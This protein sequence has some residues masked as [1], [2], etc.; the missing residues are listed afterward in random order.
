MNLPTQRPLG[1]AMTLALLL[2]TTP[3]AAPAFAEEAAANQQPS[4]A[5][6]DIVVTGAVQRGLQAEEEAAIGVLDIEETG[7]ISLR[8]QTN[9]A[10]IAKRLPGLSTSV[11]QGRNGS[12]TGEAQYVAIRG[13]QT[14]FNAYTL[15]GIRLPQTAGTGT[16]AISLN[17]F[18][19]FAISGIVA[20]K[21][22]GAAQDAD[23]IAGIIDLRTPTAF[24]FGAGFVR[25]RA[26]TQVAQR[27]LQ[28]D[29]D[30]WG[31]ALGVDGAQRFGDANQFG[32]YA[33]AYYEQRNS[34]AESVAT[35]DPW[36]STFDNGLTAR[37][38]EDALSGRGI[39][40]N[41]FNAE[42]ERYGA[43][44]S[45][46][47]RTDRLELF[48]RVNWA[49]YDIANT[50]NQT[51][52][53][54][55]TVSGQTNP[56][57][58]DA[59]GVFQPIGANP[60]H[61]FRV[62]DVEQELFSTH[63][64]G[65]WK[66]ERLSI[67][68]SGAY[69]D[70]RLDQPRSHTAAFRGI[71]YIG[72]PGQTGL[73]R[74]GVGIDISDPKWPTPI[75]SPGAADYVASLERPQ[76]YYVQ[77]NQ[78]YLSEDKWTIKGDVSWS[79]DGAL[80]LVQVGGLWEDA[81]RDGLS[82]DDGSLRYR[83]RTDLY[84]GT[85][86]GGPLA[87]F[88]GEVLDDFL[89]HRTVRPIKLLDRGT[90]EDQVAAYVPIDSL[91]QEVLNR[92]MLDGDESRK[93][94]FATATLRFEGG[95]GSLLEV[96]PGIRYEDNS[97]NASF[98]LEDD[99][100]DRFVEAG[101]NYDHLDPSLLAVWR[102]A[103]RR[104]TVRAAARRSYARPAFSNLAGPT[105]I[106]RDAITDAIISISRPN[107]DLAP[108]SAWSFDAG[109]EYRGG[110]N[111]WIQIAAYYKDLK[112]IIVPTASRE[113]GDPVDGI[114]YYTPYNGL[115]GN[116]LGVEGS[117]RLGL[118]QWVNGWAGGFG[119]GGNITLQDT[120]ATYQI[121]AEDIRTSALP[122]APDIIANAEL[123]YENGPVRANLW[124]NHIGKRLLTVVDSEPDVYAQP[125]NE[126]NLG[127]AFALTPN[128]ELGLSAR[129]L[130]NEPTYWTTVG[131]SDRYISNDRAGGYLETGR[132]FQASLT[133][134]M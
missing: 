34:V 114:I 32:I 109:I 11:D 120:Q 46:D 110:P 41:F 69:A 16:R 70:G 123:F 89:G 84:T 104:W 1:R 122:E 91:S 74:E 134:T 133:V 4:T 81:Q 31:G 22:P 98:W 126:L 85:V 124:F 79:G 71:S 108:V 35:Q 59:N 27:A 100:G 54:M 132:I 106:E 30:G 8:S 48:G 13:F 119:I 77:S 7:D 56:G 80:A 29:Q 9:I 130:T 75:L 131:S 49:R 68:L 19:P 128:A 24:D 15:D 62:E 86:S 6:N 73:A 2:S 115:G 102:G 103:D 42:I 63:V 65:R 64:G 44:G 97:Y 50:Q 94:V 40:Y 5:V 78:N 112:D 3:L 105:S 38:N 33:A 117:F 88:P 21:T 127:V 47:Y 107:P 37:E 55:E 83:F 116:A 93:A 18:S 118:D 45:L 28:Q 82:I 95:D 90:L 111:Q 57:R 10:D 17:L 66:G 20:D 96:M 72:T 113:G 99:D 61:Y 39:Q 25:A 14:G 121:S 43:S 101:R 67:G 12:A 52:I 125:L 87:D 26:L 58:Y 51:G 53:R 92:G 60:A 129:N 23:S 76:Q 36:V